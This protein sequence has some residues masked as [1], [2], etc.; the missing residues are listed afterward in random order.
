MLKEKELLESIE[1]G[2]KRIPVLL[3]ELIAARTVNPPGNEFLAARIICRE[4]KKHRIKFSKYEKIKGRTNIIAQLGKGS[5]RLC[6]ACHSDVVPAGENWKTPPFKGVVKNKKMYGRGTEDDKGP[7]AATLFVLT[8]LK[9]FEKEMNGSLIVMFAADEEAGSKLGADYLLKEKKF[10]A[11]YA[12]IPD[13]GSKMEEIT[14]GEKGIMHVLVESI[15][16]QAHGSTPQKGVNAIW[17]MNAFLN[18]L[19]KWKMKFKKVKYFS[20]PTLNI[21]LIHGGSSFN[22]VPAKCT[23]EIDIRYLPGQKAAM[24]LKEIKAIAR[25]TEKK[26]KKAK[27]KIKLIE[28]QEPFILSQTHPLI[29]SIKKNTR[30]VL[31]KTPRITTSSGTTIAKK[32]VKRKIYAIGFCPGNNQMHKSNEFIELKQ[33]EQFAKIIALTAKD[34]L[35]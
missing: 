19:K 3:K 24:L 20:K 16:K 33:L 22:T 35:F 13:I 10:K 29:K 32:F 31:K 12:I 8:V 30:K 15:G 7:L 25:K 17:N 28:K 6:I 21:G 1:T 5:P 14:I 2:K 11:D 9:K 27:F 18:E 23:T 26:N 34:L 4:L